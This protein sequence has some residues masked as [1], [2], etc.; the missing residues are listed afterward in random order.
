MTRDQVV[1]IFAEWRRRE[2]DAEE[3]FVVYEDS[4]VYAEAA[5]DYFLE[6]A[7][8]NTGETDGN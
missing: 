4:G 3:A 2:D 5:A 7:A 8:L 6:L 1:A